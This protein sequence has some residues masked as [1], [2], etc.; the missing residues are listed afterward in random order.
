MSKYYLK[1][2]YLATT[3][4]DS[5]DQVSMIYVKSMKSRRQQLMWTV[6]STKW[7]R[8]R[9]HYE[10]TAMDINKNVYH[11]HK[12]AVNWLKTVPS[13]SLFCIYCSLRLIITA[14]T[15]HVEIY[16]WIN[17]LTSRLVPKNTLPMS[18]ANRNAIDIQGWIC[19]KSKKNCHPIQKDNVTSD[20][21]KICK[22]SLRKHADSIL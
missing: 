7:M 10:L 6:V 13:K 8:T 16:I 21:T 15:T 19:Y 2:C 11:Q 3:T 20:N 4:D 12:K 1:F 22:K 9:L 14:N 17:L 18:A 5:R